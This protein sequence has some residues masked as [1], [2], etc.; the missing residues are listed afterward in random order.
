VAAA[1]LIMPIKV[2]A[3]LA[4]VTEKALA[5]RCKTV[6]LTEVEAEE[7]PQLIILVGMAV[8]VFFT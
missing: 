3:S 6:L 7:G 4:A 5:M 2:L 8:L 1:A